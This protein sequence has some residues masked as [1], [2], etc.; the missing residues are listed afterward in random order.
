MDSAGGASYSPVPAVAVVLASP[1]TRHG[2]ALTSQ[3]R[4]LNIV[5]FSH[6]FLP[7]IGGRELVV[8]HLARALL[9]QGHQVR[10]FGPYDWRRGRSVDVGFPVHRYPALLRVG[11]GRD[12]LLGY[13]REVEYAAQFTWNRLRWGCD[14]VHAHTTYPAGFTAARTR[15]RNSRWGLVV[16]PHGVDIHTIPELGHGMRLRPRLRARIARSVSGADAVTAISGSVRASLID[17]GADPAKIQDVPNGVDCE[18][19]VP[20]G[21][22]RP[23]FLDDVPEDAP[24]IVTVGNYHPRKGL[25]LIIRSMRLVAK[26][27]PDARLVIV[28][29]GKDKLEPVVESEGAVGRVILS[30]PVE[31]PFGA[32]S[33]SDGDV[34]AALL[35]RSA[36][37]VSA[38][39]EEGSEGL[40][41]AVLE[42]MAAGL[43]VVATDISG[44]RDIVESGKNGHLV[45][46]SDP[47][48]LANA[49][50]SMIEDD[51]ERGR[52]G[53][54]ARA[55]AQRYSWDAAA[56]RYVEIYEQVISE[57][58]A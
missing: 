36:V 12:G 22:A 9:R 48:A 10:V 55:C 56:R 3:V 40:S 6:T 34:L 14:V 24:L 43:P 13:L 18:R 46:P 45:P 4:M 15:S 35:E 2:Q 8:Y 53:E 19:F 38:G 29:R 41:L 57:R 44:N 30:G 33:S 58:G 28:G 16:T 25:E 1:W 49:I 47:S 37:Y 21:L 20:R 26:R 23:G 42:G 11:M 27:I 32:R 50:V 51:C 54:A 39:T 7:Q 52:M 5:L 17:A 31:F